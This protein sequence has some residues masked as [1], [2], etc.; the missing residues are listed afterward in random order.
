MAFIGK[1]PDAG[2]DWGQEEKGAT[3]DEMA[4]WHHQLNA[5][6]FERILGVGD[7][8][9]GLA[10]CDSWGH[11]GS[12]TTEQLNCTELIITDI[13]HFFMYLLTL[14]MS[15]LEKCVFESSAH[16]SI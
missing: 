9:G 8:Q 4:G 2:R 15:S 16:F 5:H 11:K 7:G 12:D 6:E 10:C 14:C 13:E 3:E 1:D